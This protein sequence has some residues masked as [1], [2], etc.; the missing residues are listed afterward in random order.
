[1][2][3]SNF[4]RI[5]G[6]TFAAAVCDE[7]AF[8]QDDT[9]ANP[10]AEVLAAIRPA[11]TT[12]HGPL[13]MITTPFA[14]AGVVWDLFTRYSG[15]EDAPVLVWRAPSRVMNPL[16]D[17]RVVLDALER[18]EAAARAEWLAEFR[19]DVA[20]FV[21][22]EAVARVVVKDRKELPARP[23]EGD[24]VSFA[25]PGRLGIGLIHARSRARRAGGRR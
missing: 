17:E 11:L 6:R 7:V 16:L 22:H 3:T 25:D 15:V 14:K 18:D 1:V 5:R 2:S 24:Y 10:A 19:V 8:W 13:V 12:L 4:R 21:S 20:A 23:A 9:G